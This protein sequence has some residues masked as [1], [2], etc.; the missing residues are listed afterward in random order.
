LGWEREKGNMRR[1]GCRECSNGKRQGL[2]VGRRDRKRESVSVRE[3]GRDKGEGPGE[4]EEEIF[5][6]QLGYRRIKSETNFRPGWDSNL[7]SL[8]Q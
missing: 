6:I 2:G 5:Q 1:R 8:S 4:R 3:G 7:R